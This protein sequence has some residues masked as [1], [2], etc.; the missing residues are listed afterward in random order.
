LVEDRD[1]D[2]VADHSEVVADGFNTP[3]DGTAAGV[4]ARGDDVWFGNIPN[5]WRLTRQAGGKVTRQQ[6]AHGFGVHI[7]VT[8]HDLHGLVFGPDGRLYLSFGDRGACVTNRE[9]RVIN[10]PD[11][12]GVLRCEPDGS[13][14]EVYCYG[15]RNPQDLEFDDEGNLW[16][17]DNDTAGADP[18]RVLHLVEGGDYGWRCS[19]Q[20]MEGFGP[21]VQE[22]L[23]RGGR[24]DILPLAG[25]VS[26]GP[27]GLAYYPGTGFG[28]RLRGKFLHCDFPAGVWAFSVRPRGASFEV[29]ASEKF[30]WNCWPTDV[31]FGPDGAAY[32]L[33]WVSGWD[34]PQKGRIYRIVDPRFINE[35]KVAEVRRLLGE[36]MSKR[37][38]AELADLLGHADR[39]V[40]LEAQYELASRKE[41]ARL[42]ETAQRSKDRYARLHAIWGIG[43][44][45]RAT[46]PN[47]YIREL[48]SLVPLIGDRDE[49]IA[50]AAMAMLGEARLVNAQP[51][52][53]ERFKTFSPRLL[54]RA[55]SADRELLA[56]NSRSGIW[57]NHRFSPELEVQ[58]VNGV[59]RM[60]ASKPN[61]EN[62]YSV[63]V[64]TGDLSQIARRVAGDDPYLALE[65]VRFLAEL[66]AG[67]GDSQVAGKHWAK[68]PDPFPRLMAL[69]A[70]E[71]VRSGAVTNFLSDAEP[72]VIDEAG[73]AIH[74][75]PIADGFPALAALVT[76]V[77][78]PT[79]L[80]SRVIDACFRLGTAQHAQMLAGFANRRDAPGWARALALKALGD[81]PKPPPID[82]VIGLWRPAVFAKEE[83]GVSAQGGEVALPKAVSNPLLERAASSASTIG[84]VGRTPK[85]PADL[86]RSVSYDEGMAVKRNDQPATRAFLRVAS[87]ILDPNTP[88]ANGV[89]LGGPPPPVEV[90]L[91]VV[92]TALQLRTKE[93][94]T[95]L[96]ARLVDAQAPKALR[97]A[98]VPALAELNAGQTSDALNLALADSDPDFQAAATPYL[99]RLEGADTINILRRAIDQITTA[100]SA[101]KP[102]A[103]Q[104]RF[105]QA[106]ILALARQP[107]SGADDTLTV[108]FDRLD[109]A[110]LP[111]AVALELMQAAQ[112]RGGSLA[113]RAR[114]RQVVIEKADGALGRWHDGVHGGDVVRG[115]QIFHQKPEVECIRCHSVAGTGG[116]VGPALDGLAKRATREQMVESIALPS[117]RFAAGYE[118]ANLELRDGRTIT[119]RVLHE[120]A[121]GLEIESPSETGE[122]QT[123][124]VAKS[125]IT[126]RAK[127]PSPMPEGLA[128][129]LNLFEMRDLVA[130]LSSLK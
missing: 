108:T 111:D 42:A 59:Y 12:G 37:N 52:I 34:M 14:L 128:D 5:L 16:T 72:D 26:Q 118:M 56:P 31:K 39:R 1:G 121:D 55:I 17:V 74:D 67:N 104:I 126:R 48:A 76:R 63:A 2:G 15:L 82:R 57:G 125:D 98:I 116:T 117:A 105:A 114:E 119:G 33:D 91:A 46:Y 78:C 84:A 19:Y 96:Y 87:E 69:H 68:N 110:K 89:V 123:L 109:Q 40:R 43:Q 30:A 83:P 10:L 95:P 124:K 61:P 70:Y 21:W 58:I 53:L 44:I 47:G 64:D 102:T 11:M 65:G 129:K 51:A 85:L 27:A 62:R 71:R 3:V 99:D 13:Q 90:Q 23:W 24:F 113:G 54:A 60:A 7:G 20:H 94:S 127:A 9:G 93:A 79:N 103:S 32:V 45:G 8:G 107:G 86:G 66:I 22:E 120:G 28:D 92:S 97:L 130:Y 18:C 35:L 73:H 29:E 77:D 88:D 100:D 80:M 81:W 115:S 122:M 4:V 101:T 49:I 25:T 36:G 106:A 41:F 75:T 6:L 50:G 112:K 38:P